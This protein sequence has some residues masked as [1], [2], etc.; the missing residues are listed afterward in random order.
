MAS[1]NEPN[2]GRFPAV[3]ELKQRTWVQIH[4]CAPRFFPGPFTPQKTAVRTG[5]IH[6]S[7]RLD[8]MDDRSE[9]RA[10]V[11]KSDFNSH[12]AG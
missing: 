6:H 3:R 11:E 12:R 8:E 10:V 1:V 9:T 5:F 7:F 2:G 4:F